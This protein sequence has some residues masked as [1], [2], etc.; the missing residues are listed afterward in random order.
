MSSGC[1]DVLSLAD[2]QTAKKHQIFEAE[3]ITGKQGGVSFGADI[4]YATN[5]VTGQTQKTLPAVLRDAGFSPVSWDFATGGTLTAT[6]RD[7]V[8]YDPVSKTWYSYT[9]SLPAVVPASFNPAGNADWKPQTDPYLRADLESPD[10]GGNIIGFRTDSGVGTTLSAELLAKYPNT[11]G[12]HATPATGEMFNSI[13]QY[14]GNHDFLFINGGSSSKS[15]NKFKKTGN[16]TV[17]LNPVAGE[18][19]TMTV[20]TVGYV[21]PVSP[22]TSGTPVPPQGTVLESLTFEGDDAGGE[23]GLAILQGF[24]FKLNKLSFRNT[25]IALWM[26]DVWMTSINNINAWG[27]IR[28]EGGT[29]TNYTNCFAKVLDPSADFGAF[30]MSNLNYS[31]MMNCASD[32]TLKTAY[33]FDNCD[34]VSVINCGCEHPNSPGG[35]YGAAISI[36]NGNNISFDRFTCI[37]NTGETNPLIAVFGGNN[38]VFNGLVVKTNST[39]GQDMFVHQG[40]N[41]IIFNNCLFGSS[42]LPKVG[43]AAAAAGSKIIVNTGSNSFIHRVTTDSVLVSFE[44]FSESGVLDSSSALTFGPAT[45]DVGG[46]IKDVKYQKEG[47]IVTVEFFLQFSTTPGQSGAMLLRNLPFAAKNVASGSVSV[48]S[49]LPSGRGSFSVT[50]DRGSNSLQFFKSGNPSFDAVND[51]D[52]TATTSIRGAI[53]YSINS[54]FL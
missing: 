54:Q 20:D 16:A 47:G 38:V 24:D 3:V 42:E 11:T 26:K 18:S 30:R 53:T 10:I 52:I 27:Q 49:N 46:V 21:N 2:L 48:T 39:Y 41:T 28:H 45:S 35:G 8:V 17:T 23:C 1:G 37:P 40:G 50:I 43:V 31:T 14:K 6:D 19:P 33:W 29:S 44:A 15:T 4:D 36:A 25:K 5:Q 13:T 22:D 9:G 34:G 7:K 12:L 51:S 32:G